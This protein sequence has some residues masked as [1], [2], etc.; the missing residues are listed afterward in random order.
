ML[1]YKNPIPPKLLGSLALLLVLAA[2]SGSEDSASPSTVKDD[3]SNTPNTPLACDAGSD[4]S[5]AP[6]PQDTTKPV[7]PVQPYVLT[8]DTVTLADSGTSTGTQGKL[9]AALAA[10]GYRTQADLERIGKLIIQGGTLSTKDSA[11]FYDAKTGLGMNKLQELEVVGTA[12]FLGNGTKA[13]YFPDMF[14]NEDQ[15]GCDLEGSATSTAVSD[16]VAGVIPKGMFQSHPSLRRATIQNATQVASQAFTLIPTLQYLDLP[17]VQILQSQAFAMQKFSS[18]SQLMEIRLPSLKTSWERTFYYNVSLNKLVLGEKPPYF[19]APASKEGLWFSYATQVEIYVPSKASY[20]ANYLNSAFIS[21]V[22]FSSFP[23][24]ALNGDTITT[25]PPINA[26]RDRCF[27]NLRTQYAGSGPYNGKYKYSLQL[28]SFNSPLNRAV[29]D[30]ATAGKELSDGS[31]GWGATNGNQ[32]NTRDAMQWTKDKGFDQVDVAFYY[33]PG[34][35]NTDLPPLTPGA[36]CKPGNAANKPGDCVTQDT[37][38]ARIDELR[39]WSNAIGIDIS[40][41]GIQNSFA[42]SLQKRRDLDLDRSRFYLEMTARLG[43][44]MMRIFTGPPPVQISRV[45]WQDLMDSQIIPLVKKLAQYGID[46]NLRDRNGNYVMIGVQN[47]GDM[48]STANQVLYF[49]SQMKDASGKPYP[50]V[51]MID[52]TGYYRPFNSIDSSQTDWYDEI[53]AASPVGVSL[54]IKKKPGGAETSQMMDLPKL[55]AG[56]RSKGFGSFQL[57]NYQYNTI[58]IEVLWAPGDADYPENLADKNTVMGAYYDRVM[59]YTQSVWAA[60]GR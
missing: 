15:S 40:G 14:P 58:Q 39:N 32:I 35:S 9:A 13:C 2:C 55:F 46:H 44:P 53:A 1:T 38:R 21:Y 7:S 42:D 33:L 10:A 31:P 48:L 25:P 49:Y 50:N 17:R 57:P 19:A 47:H 16:A 30:G 22:D 43:A 41:T 20:D 59:E 3:S 37:I 45:S 51:R 5:A 52:D 6:T 27:N 12:N 11:V 29:K 18:D 56:V 60:G 26:Y 28:Y 54:Q 23:A 36:G 4:D 24:H 8:G 34:Y